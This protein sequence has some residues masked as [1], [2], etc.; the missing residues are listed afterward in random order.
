MSFHRLSLVYLKICK[1]GAIRNYC[2]YE[3]NV[4]I[5]LTF[6]DK[7]NISYNQVK[8]ACVP[9]FSDLRF[10]KVCRKFQRLQYILY[11]GGKSE[12]KLHVPINI[13][14]PDCKALAIF[15]LTPI[16]NDTIWL[17]S[18]TLFAMLDWL[19]C[20]S[21]L[22]QITCKYGIIQSSFIWVIPAKFIKSMS[23]QKL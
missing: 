15:L 10:V 13:A 5:L 4:I 8:I 21:W 7:S 2:Q 17:L 9:N 19:R 14:F 22:L 16:F 18:R 1:E 3:K 12:T 6:E 23:S 20:Q 11:L